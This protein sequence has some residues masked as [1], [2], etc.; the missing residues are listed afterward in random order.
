MADLFTIGV[1]GFTVETFLAELDRAGVKLVLDVRQ[2]RGVRGA[3]YSWANSQRLQA[4]LDEAGLDYEHHIELAPTTEMRK[5]QYAEDDKRGIAR[6]DRIDLAPAYISRYTSE[7][8]D[9]ADLAALATTVRE[10]GPAVLMCVE[11]GPE[12]CHRSLVAARM[13]DRHGVSIDH[14][15]PSDQNRRRRTLMWRRAR[16]SGRLDRPAD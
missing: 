5:T 2:R 12:A 11:R 9:R 14:L 10:R 3:E 6:R 13:A 4:A 15:R 8:I 1:Y 16:P 7:I